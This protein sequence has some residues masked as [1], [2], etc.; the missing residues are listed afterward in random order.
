[1][2]DRMHATPALRELTR[3]D[4][5]ALLTGA[6][7]GRVAVSI[8]ALPAVFPVFLT[9]VDDRIVFRTVPGT[10]LNAAMN[11]AIVAVE[12]DDFDEETGTGWS[13]LVR[14]VAH[15]LVDGAVAETARGALR[16]TW[17]EPGHEYLV[18]VTTDLVTGRRL[19]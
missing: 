1:M 6:Q 4:A 11:G 3:Q 15:V 7:L 19:A 18:A 16:T 9:L 14:G 13:V 5:L 12:A 10:K 8:D 2:L 17:L